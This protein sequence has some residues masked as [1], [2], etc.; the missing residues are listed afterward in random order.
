V[1][2]CLFAAA[3]QVLHVG[4][5]P[6]RHDH[7]GMKQSKKEQLALDLLSFQIILLLKSLVDRRRQL[8]FYLQQR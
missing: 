5:E 1:G 6:P 2:V 8:S 3:T 4:F 7:N